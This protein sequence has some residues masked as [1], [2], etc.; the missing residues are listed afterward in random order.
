MGKAST[1]TYEDFRS[2][3][4]GN[5]GKIPSVNIIKAALG[6][7]Q[8]KVVAWREQYILEQKAEAESK[9]ASFVTDQMVGAWKELTKIMV[10]CVDGYKAEMTALMADSS[11]HVEQMSSQIADLEYELAQARNNLD[12]AN[13]EISAL[14]ARVLEKNEALSEVRQD[15]EKEAKE[16]AETIQ[17]LTTELEKAKASLDNATNEK[18]VVVLELE[19][20][21]QAASDARHQSEKCIGELRNQVENLTSELNTVKTAQKVAEAKEKAAEDRAAALLDAKKNAEA[22][23]INAEQARTEAAKRHH[24]ELEAADAKKMQLANEKQALEVKLQQ[25]ISVLND[26]FEAQKAEL[27]KAKEDIK[28]A[29]RLLDEAESRNSELYDANKKL[30]AQLAS[31]QGSGFASGKSATM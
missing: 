10:N 23:T 24:L 14:N 11:A 4:A 3:I 17:R 8:D 2:Y 28:E 16:A 22:A 21:K 5:G 25:K 29:N 20:T 31:F 27:D 9:L 7:G 30:Q 12:T 26:R 1:T 13:Q 19:K 18:K 6:I 15:N